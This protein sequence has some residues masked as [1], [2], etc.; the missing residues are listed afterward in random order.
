MSTQNANLS[1]DPAPLERLSGFL[2]D[3]PDVEFAVLVGS[4]ADGSAI[5]CSDWDIALQLQR[6]EN[7]YMG[8]L[9]RM[10]TL[11][12]EAATLLDTDPDRVDLISAP[13]AKLAMRDLIANHGIVLT[14]STSLP[15]LH[16]LQRTWRDLEDYYWD[17]LYGS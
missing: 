7:T 12:H 10:E 1:D 14:D 2:R 8:E 11:R 15:W 4:R 9:A 17:D 3:Q 5:P 16:F 13:S 6:K